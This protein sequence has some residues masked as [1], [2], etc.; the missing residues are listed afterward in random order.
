M[1]NYYQILDIDKSANQEEIKTAFR[2]KA[3]ETH[4]DMHNGSEY[5]TELFKEVAEA[6]D[7]LSN[8]IRR[9]KYDKALNS[10]TAYNYEENSGF[11]TKE[12]LY[13]YIKE[14]IIVMTAQAEVAKIKAKSALFKGIFWL[15]LGVVITCIS[16]FSA[17]QNGGGTYYVM[18]GAIVFG[19]IQA[20]RA[21]IAYN[22]INNAIHEYEKEIWD[23]IK[24]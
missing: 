11:N 21:F 2:K 23:S 12:D 10:G 5:Y 6:Y 16:Y 7:V 20:I 19:G 9:S 15:V 4:P 3:K 22:R 13:N 8:P 18:G 14:Y 1:K 17:V 24:L